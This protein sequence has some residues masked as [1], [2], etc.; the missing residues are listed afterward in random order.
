MCM[1]FNQKIKRMKIE[2]S[3]NNKSVQFHLFFTCFYNF[4]KVFTSQTIAYFN[5]NNNTAK[6]AIPKSSINVT[7]VRGIFKNVPKQAH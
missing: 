2:K 6:I 3:S 1:A 7:F 5:N 4:I